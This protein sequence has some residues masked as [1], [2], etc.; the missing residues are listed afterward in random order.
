VG[1]TLTV[2]VADPA[3]SIPPAAPGLG[4]SSVRTA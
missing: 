2:G 3:G 4:W 1:S